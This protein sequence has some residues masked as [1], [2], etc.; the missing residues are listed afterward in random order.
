ML[1]LELKN[2]TLLHDKDHNN[3]EVEP[4][5]FYNRSLTNKLLVRAEVGVN[6]I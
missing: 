3:P 5:K 6:H 2:P 1:N 4:V